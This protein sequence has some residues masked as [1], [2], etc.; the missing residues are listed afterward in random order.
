MSDLSV[1]EQDLLRRIDEDE[2]LRPLFFRK[3]K[4]L[5]WFDPLAKLSYF[6]PEKNPKPVPAKEEGFVNIPFWSVVD[7]LVKTAPELSDEENLEYV[8]KFLDIL[9]RATSYAKENKFSN[10]KTWWKFSEIV[11]QIPHNSITVENLD[12]I[13]YWLDDKYD[14]G[15]VAEVIGENWLPSLLQKGEEHAL[16]L[17]KRVIELLYKIIFGE[18]NSGDRSKSGAFLRVDYYRAQKITIK[19]AGLAGEKLG[20]EAV[21]IFDVFVK[22]I[23]KQLKNDLYSSLWQP[24]IED[25]EQNK[26]R[27]NAE[28]LLIQAYRDSV[29]SYINVSQE[30]ASSYVKSLL[31][32]EYQTVKR[33]AIYVV[34]RNYDL[35]TDITDSILKSE[36]FDSNYR[37]EMW[38]FINKCYKRFSGSQKVKL[39]KLIDRIERHDDKGEKHKGASA[40]DKTIWL[41]AIKDYGEKEAKLYIENTE[42]AKTEPD[43]PDFS[44]Y[45]SIGWRG[46]ESPKTLEELQVLSVDGLIQELVDYEDPGDFGGPGLEGLVKVFKELIKTKPLNYYLNLNKFVQLD[47]AYIHEIIEAYR[48]LWIEKAKLPWEIPSKE[49]NLLQIDIG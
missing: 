49:N 12:I 11:S 22:S 46:L 1:K 28:N 18:G 34:S 9:V 33:L 23:L 30:E 36:Y 40:Y 32:S 38:H 41:A 37:H 27:N 14:V 45:M 3:V 21:Q 8:E 35:F 47:L 42:V 20:L 25:H 19:I 13:D 10:Y 15:L 31:D 6:S 2:E 48:E 39:L 4:G 16:H 43:H 26:H 7:Y 5:K 29:D 24:A 44:S 17:A